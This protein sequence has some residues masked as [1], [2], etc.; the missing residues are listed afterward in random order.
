MIE[1]VVDQWLGR[2]PVA[3]AELR[4]LPQTAAAP[5]APPLQSF[6]QLDPK[7]MPAQAPASAPKPVA[8]VCEEDVRNAILAHAKIV[9][10]RKT[11]ITPSAREL[12]EANDVFVVD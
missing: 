8:F 1:S 4:P 7:P 6:Q 3:A 9:I 11:I 5:V 12:A 10:S 2:R